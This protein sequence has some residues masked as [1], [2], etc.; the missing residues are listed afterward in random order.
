MV[1]CRLQDKSIAFPSEDMK[2]G[3]KHE[4]PLPKPAVE[5]LLR[6]L[7]GKAE[8]LIFPGRNGGKLDPKT[9][10]LIARSILPDHADITVHGFRSTFSDW[11]GEETEFPE[12]LVSFALAHKIQGVEGHY[13]R[14][15]AFERRGVLMA[16]WAQWCADGT[17]PEQARKRENAA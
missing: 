10:L 1:R 16:A 9:I 3:L 6:V 4:V 15:A 5:L 7:R 11:R 14:A 8:D 12:E 2:G 13:R 17:V